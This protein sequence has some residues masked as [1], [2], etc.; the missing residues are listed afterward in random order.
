MRVSRS[1]TGAALFASA[2]AGP[3]G[4]HG[5]SE[6]GASPRQSELYV[7]KNK[8][9]THST[10]PQVPG[11]SIFDPTAGNV[12]VVAQLAAMTKLGQSANKI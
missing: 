5:F 7:A 3:H 8:E 9:F 4:L 2:N 6:T 12:G 10:N 11:V 1:R